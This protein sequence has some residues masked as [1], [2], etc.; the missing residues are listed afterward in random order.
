MNHHDCYNCYVKTEN[1]SVSSFSCFDFTFF[2]T[3]FI[4]SVTSLFV[5][6]KIESEKGKY[7]KFLFKKI[8][9]FGRF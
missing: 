8:R 4:Q 7:N 5:I 1:I 2:F 3:M 9:S 6:S